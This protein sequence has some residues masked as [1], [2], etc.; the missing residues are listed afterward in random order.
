M[1]R[2]GPSA[3]PKRWWLV[4]TWRLF[5]GAMMGI[6]AAVVACAVLTFP[7]L[8]IA[9]PVGSSIVGTLIILVGM[10]RWQY[11]GHLKRLG[12]VTERDRLDAA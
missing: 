5:G 2:S 6:G 7:H 1:I 11:A 10:E 8:G 9:L 3:R 12:R 4:L